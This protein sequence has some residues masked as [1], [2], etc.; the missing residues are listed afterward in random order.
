MEADPVLLHRTGA[1]R[2]DMKR[3]LIISR[4]PAKNGNS[5]LLASEFRSGAEEAG[6][7]VEQIFLRRKKI[8]YCRACN[9]C[10]RPESQ[11]VCA[12]R[13]DMAEILMK[14]KEADII[15][16]GSPVYYYNVSA[17]MKTFIDRTY[18]D[19]MNLKDKE[20]YYILSCADE[21]SGSIDEAVRAL[22]GFTVCLPGS[23]EKGTV[24]GLGCPSHGSVQ[25]QASMQEA[26]EMG[27]TV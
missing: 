27:K 19:F 10:K 20:F 4:S 16:L 25:G 26:Y 6:N 3:V 21:E 15:V 2:R 22:H 1:L 17:Q 23:L 5:D 11:G 7:A 13:D 14:M 12:F 8:G 24:Y 18:A 9:Y